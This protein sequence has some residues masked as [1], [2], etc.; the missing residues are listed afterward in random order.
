MIRVF[1]AFAGIGGFRSGLE[2]VGGF[3]IVGWCE[4]DKFAQKAYRI[5][6]D[7]GKEEFYEDITKID[8][9]TMPDFDLLVGGPPCQSW[10]YA[11]LRKGF[12][13]D[14]GNMFLEYIRILEAKKPKYFV[15]ENVAGLLSH[16]EGR[17]Y[18][19][20]LEKICELGYSVCWRVLNSADFNVAQSR[21]RVYIIGFLREKCAGKVL[22]FTDANPKT[23]VQRIPGREGCRVYSAEGLSIT[24]TSQAGGF[25]G[26]TGLYE[27][28]GLPIKVKTKSGYQIALPGDS[29]DLAYPN[30]NSRRGRVGHDIAHTLT[31]SCNQGYYAM[32][33]DMNP[34]PKITELARC[35][36]TRQDSGIS[37]HKGEHSGV[38]V[39]SEP[40]AVLTPGKEKVRQ[41][42]RRFKLPD[43]P[44][45]TLTVTDKHGVIY[46]GL[47]RRLMP[48]ECFRLQ[49]FTDEQFNK[50]RE[51]GLSDAQ[52]YKLA[53]N[54]VTVNVIE[55]I[56]RNLLEFD[57]EREGQK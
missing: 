18:G 13:D 30:L 54:A 23:L 2:R 49:G 26:K 45:F 27:I 53:G 15:A 12:E 40:I 36:T 3:K 42:G 51:A 38:I 28:M 17:S 25:G 14:R 1:E 5:L 19:I 48:L 21:K 56:G 24:L 44:M 20:I 46:C 37:K 41:Q 39:I 33:I 29:I 8:Y 47:I 6:F 43:E 50:V 22:S 16:S 55:A 34:N 32:F 4:I 57:K 9:R 11:G 10:S 52:L 35:I 7:T 31:T